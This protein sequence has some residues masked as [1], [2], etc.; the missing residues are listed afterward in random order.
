MPWH[1]LGEVGEVLRDLGDEGE[2]ARCAVVRIFLHEVEKR[3]GHDSGTQ[4]AQEER[5][6]NQ[7]LADVRPAAVTALL[8]P[9]RKHLLQ[10]TWEHAAVMR[11]G[12]EVYNIVLQL[13]NQVKVKDSYFTLK[14][15]DINKD[16]FN[17]Y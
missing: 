2:R 14:M 5:G 16:K 6:T 8:P 17:Q 10:L 4:K 1:S 12:K 13:L 15:R 11:R 7:T 9:G 3:R